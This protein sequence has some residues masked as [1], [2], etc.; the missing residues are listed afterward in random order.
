MKNNAKVFLGIL[1]CW[2][3]Y[4]LLSFP[5]WHEPIMGDE[6]QYALLVRGL[7]HPEILHS[8]Q[9]IEPSFG[10]EHPP[11]YAH[12]L[13]LWEK[14]SVFNALTSKIP[15][16]VSFLL[17]L[18]FIYL[19]SCRLFRNDPKR[20][21]IGFLAC[22]LFSI[23]PM[24]V[25][26]SL[27]MD[28][29]GT[30]LNAAALV[31]IY[32]LLIL[33]NEEHGFL[34]YFLCAAGLALCFWVKLATPLILAGSFLMYFCLI[35]DFGR[36]RRLGAIVA[37]GVVLFSLGWFFYAQVRQ[38]SFWSLTDAPLSVIRGFMGKTKGASGV[39]AYTR[40]LWAL[41][42]WCS[43]S[44][45]ALG[46]ASLIKTLMN[47]SQRAGRD[48]LLFL[49]PFAFYGVMVFV[50]YF[51]IGGLTHSFPKYHFAILPVFAIMVSGFVI[52]RV[53]FDH[54]LIWEAFLLISGLV[55]LMMVLPVGDPLYTI[56]Y[57]LKEDMAL[58][59]GSGARSILT[60][61]L[62]QM[63]VIFA[64]TGIAFVFFKALKRPK[65]WVLSLVAS[66]IACNLALDIVQMRA[67]YN[68]VYCYGA[69]KVV[70]AAGFVRSH[71]HPSDKICVPREI[72]WLANKNLSSYATLS[73]LRKADDFLAMLK[74]GDVS[75]VVYG[76][77]GNTVQQYR[78]I[79]NRDEIRSFL[80]DAYQSFTI[81]SYQIWLRK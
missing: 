28:M 53:D 15:G 22:L 76:I 10:L 25:R 65:A 69:D 13:A 17:S 16:L 30:L 23:N 56:N 77:S 80:N 24:A 57:A 34:R 5:S 32:L 4:L 78:E 19:I 60:R 29:D 74:K 58:R 9:I 1:L 52:R 54:R 41:L 40:N 2:V 79:F 73:H 68:T 14:Y 45:I 35:R 11:L 62:F 61:E 72:L 50:T 67:P 47:S 33:E 66:V 49:G 3:I 26:G 20:A 38:I 81:G 39:A 27:L 31:F 18:I 43:P 8:L 64:T 6:V 75:C 7:V 46:L 70:L 51:F 48:S 44:F 36:A 42:I 59:G 37:G 12:V 63:G 21:A 55:L 71:T